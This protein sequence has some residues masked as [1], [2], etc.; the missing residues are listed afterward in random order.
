VLAETLGGDAAPYLVGAVLCFGTLAATWRVAAR[1]M[2]P[3]EA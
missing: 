3:R 2:R 1:G